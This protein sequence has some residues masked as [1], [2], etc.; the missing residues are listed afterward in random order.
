MKVTLE[1]SV[2]IVRS[3]SAK[4]EPPIEMTDLQCR[5]QSLDGHSPPWATNL[6]VLHRI[7]THKYKHAM[8]INIHIYIQILKCIHTYIHTYIHIHANAKANKSAETPLAGYR[9]RRRHPGDILQLR[10]SLK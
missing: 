1:G 9:T 5:H 10:L 2:T 6:H 7:H 8:Q 4:A 3:A